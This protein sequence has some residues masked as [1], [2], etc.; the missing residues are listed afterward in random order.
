[1]P[2]LLLSFVPDTPSRL[3]AFLVS[4]EWVPQQP[5]EG[6]FGALSEVGS[7]YFGT[8][9][10]RQPWML[11][12][13]FSACVLSVVFRSWRTMTCLGIVCI[14]L[15]VM[16]SS[17]VYPYRYVYTLPAFIFLLAFISQHLLDWLEHTQRKHWQPWYIGLL[18]VCLLGNFAVEPLIRTIVVSIHREAFNY[19]RIEDFIGDEINPGDRVF[20]DFPLF[21][22]VENRGGHLITW[23]RD[24]STDEGVTY[25]AQMPVEGNTLLLNQP[26]HVAFLRTID[27]L[28]FRY[29]EDAPNVLTSADRTV[30]FMQQ[31]TLP[32][33]TSEWINFLPQPDKG[34]EFILYLRSAEC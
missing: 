33:V 20:G 29:V 22:A 11:L 6:I 3:E 4:I 23:F 15:A 26:E 10:N 21:Y 28:V 8:F 12:L 34:Y 13:L 19:Q 16:F 17:H 25:W 7:F 18:V 1:V 31:Q 14:G 5:A 9:Y 32:P 2:L 27:I 30:C 24:I